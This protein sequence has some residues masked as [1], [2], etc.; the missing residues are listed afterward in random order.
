MANNLDFNEKNIV[1][2]TSEFSSAENLVDEYFCY[3]FV[4]IDPIPINSDLT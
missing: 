2:E 3:E 1:I 4:S